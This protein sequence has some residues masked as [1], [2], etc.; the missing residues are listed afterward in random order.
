MEEIIDLEGGGG[1]VVK[2]KCC[3]GLTGVSTRKMMAK[4]GG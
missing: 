2:S 3:Q 1:V 4:S